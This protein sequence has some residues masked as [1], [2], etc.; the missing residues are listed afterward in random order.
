ME[1]RIERKEKQWGKQMQE[2]NEKMKIVRL[3]QEKTIEER[4]KLMKELNRK[5]TNHQMTKDA[6]E[7]ELQIVMREQA[8]SAMIQE[9]YVKEISRVKHQ[10]IAANETEEEDKRDES[11]MTGSFHLPPNTASSN[12][13]FNGSKKGGAPGKKS[14]QTFRRFETSFISNHEF[15]KAAK[16]LKPTLRGQQQPL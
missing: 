3:N 15:N 7:R 12:H 10:I 2:H 1:L 14:S 5:K 6:W 16:S 11:N 4:D 13:R 8:V 9:S